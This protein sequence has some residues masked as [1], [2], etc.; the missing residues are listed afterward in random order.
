MCVCKVCQVLGVS[1]WAV[2]GGKYRGKC[3]LVYTCVRMYNVFIG[4]CFIRVAISGVC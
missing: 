4:L 3:V 1:L 2:C